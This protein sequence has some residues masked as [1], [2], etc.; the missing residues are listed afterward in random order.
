MN[1]QIPGERDHFDVVVTAAH[2]DDAEI[3]I[4]GTMARLADEGFSVL[5]VNLTDGEP[6]PLGTHE[7][8]LAEADKAAKILGISRITLDFQNRRLFD[9]FEARVALGDLFRR[10]T[11]RIVITMK[12]KTVMASPDHQQTQLITEAAVFYSRLSKWPE[13][14]R[15]PVHAVKQLFYFPIR[16]RAEEMSGFQFVIDVSRTMDRKMAALAAYE[17]QFPPEKQSFLARIRAWNHYQGMQIGVE[18]GEVLE[19]PRFPIIEPADLFRI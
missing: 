7:I 16:Q 5:L 17:S 15:Y 19:I 11:P 4:G 13:H 12:G 14:F 8:R 3:G 6:T 9:S 2:P 1:G 18:A 10:H